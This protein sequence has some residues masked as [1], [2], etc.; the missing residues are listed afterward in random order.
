MT[1]QASDYR[2][3]AILAA[4]GVGSRF[5]PGGNA[6]PKQILELAGKPLYFWSLDR[7]YSHPRIARVVIVAHPSIIES[8]RAETSG[9]F[10]RDKLDLVEGGAS[11]QESV[12]CGLK[13]LTQSEPAIDF[14]LVHDAA[15]P[16][17]SSAMIDKTIDCVIEYGACTVAVP[18]SD[19]VKRVK[20]GTIT[21]TIDRA[22]LYAV[23]TPQAA[24]FDWLLSA[25]E[26][27]IADGISATDDAFVLEH[28]GRQ[29][30]I[31]EGDRYNIKVT[32][33]QDL[34]LCNAL[35][36]NFIGQE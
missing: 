20:N 10:S 6:Q 11:R 27:A 32:V 13:R 28:A 25:H 4:G 9:V 1:K 12:F 16:F 19:T 26:A 29:V 33:S 23:H 21:D 35:A 5:T 17:L 7:L 24:K 34:I 15:R 8:M 3:G 14:V 30:R 2:F 36:P 18:V 31:V 22:D